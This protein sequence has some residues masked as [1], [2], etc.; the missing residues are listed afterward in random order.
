[1]QDPLE[2]RKQEIQMELEK[3]KK[4][5]ME[6][7]LSPQQVGGIAQQAKTTHYP[8]SFFPYCLD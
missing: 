6:R 4:I 5:Q 7:P 1:L 8:L 3:K 2:R